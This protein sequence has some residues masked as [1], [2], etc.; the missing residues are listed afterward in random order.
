M[1]L[2][3]QFIERRADPT[4]A[5]APVQ[6]APPTPQDYVVYVTYRDGVPRR[7]VV[8]ATCLFSAHK[9]ARAYTTALFP[10]EPLAISVRLA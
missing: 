4:P 5:V 2:T 3:P 8:Q 6:P 9:A 1:S 7:R 10:R